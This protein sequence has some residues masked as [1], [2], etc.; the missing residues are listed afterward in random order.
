MLTHL[1]GQRPVH[2][3]GHVPRLGIPR[4]PRARQRARGA[5]HMQ[6]AKSIPLAPRCGHDRAH[7]LH[8]LKLQVGRVRGVHRRGL[9][10]IEEERGARTVPADACGAEIRLEGDVA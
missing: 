10:S 8:V 7:V 9:H 2:L 6:R 1:R 4:R 5:T 3:H